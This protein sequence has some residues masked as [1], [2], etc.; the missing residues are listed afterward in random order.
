MIHLLTDFLNISVFGVSMHLNLMSTFFSWLVMLVIL[1]NCVFM[2]SNKEIPKSEYAH[3]QLYE[4]FYWIRKRMDS[5]F[6]VLVTSNTQT[7]KNGF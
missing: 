1:V 4:P 5:I 7:C 6:R 3:S 2:A